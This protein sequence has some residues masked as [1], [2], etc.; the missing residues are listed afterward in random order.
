M[1]C[2]N[3]EDFDSFKGVLVLAEVRDGELL[4]CTKELVSEGRRLADAMKSELYGLILGA[5]VEKFA[6][7]MGGYGADKV[8]VCE[9]ALLAD[10]TAE[11]YA[12]VICQVVEELKPDTLLV[13]ATNVGRALAPRCAARLKT[14][15]NADCTLLHSDNG[16]YRAYLESNSSLKPEEIDAACSPDTLKMTMPAFGGHMMATIT[17]PEYRPQMATVRP[18]VME[19]S[20]YNQAKAYACAVEYPKFA[21]SGDDVYS[22]VLETVKEIRNTVDVTKAEVIVSVGMGIRKDP[23]L[24]VELARQLAECF[25]GVVG[26]T[27][28]VMTEGWVAEEFMIGQTGKIVRP[29]LYIALGISGAIQHQGGMKDSGFIVAVNKDKCAPIADI[30]DVVLSGDLYDIVPA[31]IKAAKKA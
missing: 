26:C 4:D 3:K 27:R 23:K 21:L 24:G 8:F 31:M 6:S 11:A 20:E 17:C 1:K 18:G 28:D 16:E 12:N 29:K 25:G 2:V 30:A 14:G 10:Y 15:L 19:V 5:D 13:S 22:Q 7:V 9:N